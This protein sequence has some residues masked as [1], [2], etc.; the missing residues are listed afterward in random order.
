MFEATDKEIARVVKSL[1]ANFFS[2]VEY[3]ET[4]K[5]ATKLALDLIPLGAKVAYGGSTTL[6][7]L[8]LIPQLVARGTTV[9]NEVVPPDLPQALRHRQMARECDVFLA[10][11]NAVTL[12]GKLVNV[13]GGGNRVSA[14][15]FGPESVILIIGTNKIV[16]NVDEA[17]KRIRNVIAPNNCQVRGRKTP[18]A[19]TLRCN[20]CK[21]PDRACRAWLIMEKKTRHTKFAII[22]VGEDLGLG[23]DPD[24]PQDRKDKILAMHRKIPASYK[25]RA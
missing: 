5:A 14:M 8:D 25:A 9:L 13:D 6:K 7:Q 23:W 21:S 18:C 22:I 10:S 15:A 16:P 19:T 3:V 4:G 17:M 11:S 1:K 2:P 24:W 12:D 20:D